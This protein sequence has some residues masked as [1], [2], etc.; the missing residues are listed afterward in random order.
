MA[1]KGNNVLAM[2]LV[3]FF[4]DI[5]SEMIFPLLPFFITTVLGAPVAVLGLI[6]GAAE[7]TAALLKMGS[8]FVS[9]RIGKR[10]AIVVSGYSLSALSKPLF[11]VATVWQHVLAVRILDRIGKGIRD[12]PRDALLAASAIRHGRSFGFVQA[13]DRGGAVV[14]TVIATVLLAA[15]FTYRQIFL[16][17]FVPSLVSAAVAAL[18]I[19]ELAH[20]PLRKIGWPFK[21]RFG[22]EFKRFL[23]AAGLFNIANFSYAFYLLKAQQ[24][25]I[26]I[27][28]IPMV[29]LLFNICYALAAYPAGRLSDGIGKKRTIG[30]G[31]VLF[32][33]VAL[34]FAT[35]ADASLIWPFFVLYGI[36]LAFTDSISRAFVS[37]LAEDKGRGTALGAYH[38]TVGLAA[39]P[40]S[41]IAGYIWQSFGSAAMFSFSAVL[42]AAALASLGL[43]RNGSKK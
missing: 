14:G 22:G 35:T 5:G 24:A 33:L 23:F 20:A 38:M 30:I 40:A 25:G 15:A 11:S 17:A 26:A 8:G 21:G 31:Y 10:K 16:I 9:D 2:G 3:S 27:V 37:D 29:Y 34:G 28:L 43:V 7:S 41:A 32:I 12:A 19:R 36:Q 1:K 4:N 18:F 42:A 39:F 6:E 13:M